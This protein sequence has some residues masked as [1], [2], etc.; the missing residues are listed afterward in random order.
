MSIE[1]HGRPFPLELLTATDYPT[2]LHL[3]EW[4]SVV[5]TAAV[6]QVLR[7]TGLTMQRRYCIIFL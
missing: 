6:S 1:C 5:L 7:S 2:R 4:P 3:I